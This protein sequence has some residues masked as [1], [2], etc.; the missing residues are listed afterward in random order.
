MCGGRRRDGAGRRSLRPAW[1]A[2]SPLVPPLHVLE[3]TLPRPQPRGSLCCPRDG[4][5]SH[6]GPSR[7]RPFSPECCPRTLFLPSAPM[8]FPPPP[9]ATPWALG[10]CGPGLPWPRPSPGQGP[11]PTAAWLSPLPLSTVVSVR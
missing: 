8:R 1:A 10:L 7:A 11:L 9:P 3:A 4:R 2:R 5:S 6:T